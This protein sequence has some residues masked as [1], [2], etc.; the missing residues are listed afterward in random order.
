MAKATCSVPG[1]PGKVNARGWC[2]G[3][4]ARW[5]KTG[6]VQADVPLVARIPK[7]ATCKADRCENPVLA[8]ELCGR[9]Y[10]L[11]RLYGSTE[12]RPRGGVPKP[13]RGIYPPGS[14]SPHEWVT[15]KACGTEALVRMGGEGY[16]SKMCASR[17][18]TGEAH[19]LWKGD[20]AGYHPMHARVYRARGKADHCSQCGRGDDGVL[21]D[22]ANLTGKY[23]DIW[24]YAPMCRSCH[25]AY[26]APLKARGSANRNAKL[27]E[28][29]VLTARRRYDA[30]ES[31]Y[32]LAREYD[33]SGVAMAHAVFGRTWKHVGPGVVRRVRG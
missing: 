15:C 2:G 21:Y 11:Q 31:T 4:Y 13:R 19:P 9:H 29:I 6:D 25:A 20:E 26:D 16:C 17:H 28:E 22:W 5:K 27:T 10:A 14:K 23:E 3:H 1:C 30:G 33:V 32:A 8:R 24:D 12:D 7:D 18:R